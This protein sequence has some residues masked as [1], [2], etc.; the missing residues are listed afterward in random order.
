[1]A[2]IEL[3]IANKRTGQIF[4]ASKSVT[5]CEWTTNRTGAAGC[6]KF[7][8]VKTPTLDFVEGDTVRFSVD[9][10]LQF[11]GWVF[12]KSK[13]RWGV[14]EVTC[15]DRLRYLKANASYAFYGL[16]AADI[17]TQIAEDLQIEVSRL[18]RTGYTL[19]SLVEQDQSCLD[20]IE[21]SLQLTLLN[22]GKIYVLYDDGNGLTLNTPADMFS[23]V[24]LGDNSLVT[25][26]NYKTDI[27]T[28]T[29][30]YIKLSHPNEA[31]GRSDVY[32]AEDSA[33]IARWG[34]LQL[35]QTVDGDMNAAQ[36]KAQAKSTLEY[37]S[38]RW[39]SLSFSALGVPGLRAGQLIYM[40]IR[41]LGD[42]D[43]DQYL[44][45]DKIT[46]TWKNDLHTMEIETYGLQ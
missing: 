31:T 23:G 16:D 30:N 21:K 19:P 41:E 4:E 10:E 7:T 12:T 18:T 20:I 34:K 26:Y 39:K 36:L 27:D 3:I 37:Y 15:Y 38:R 22:T 2:K 9:G 28:Q 40:R 33:N 24:M 32:I 17:I 43:L 29:Y 46:H 1:M 45:I 35:Y 11:F 44:M 13:D 8:I 14:I 42:I 25:D 5:F 6:F